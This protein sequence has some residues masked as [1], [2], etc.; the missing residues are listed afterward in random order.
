MSPTQTFHKTESLTLKKNIYWSVSLIS[1]FS[2]PVTLASEAALD[3]D[4]LRQHIHRSYQAE[5]KTLADIQDWPPYSLAF[6]LIIP[7]SARYLPACPTPVH[8]EGNDNNKMPIG[9]LKRSVSCE[10]IASPWRFSV[11][12]KSEITLPV[13]TANTHIQRGNKIEANALTLSPRQIKRSE[14]F[15][16]NT[17]SLSGFKAK[18]NIRR[19]QLITDNHLIA[20]PLI[21]S[22]DEVIIVAKKGNFRAVTKGV[23]LEAGAKGEQITVKNLSSNKVV[24]VIITAQGKV[25]TLF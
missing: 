10:D 21:E 11:V 25:Q 7:S 8:I 18:R 24:S 20:I 9:Q 12:I 2:N 6:D 5:I 15:Y 23:A 19:G 3:I 4:E 16:T 22:G 17:D 14:F 13:V 1:L